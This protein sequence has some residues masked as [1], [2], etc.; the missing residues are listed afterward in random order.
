MKDLLI[1]AA[2]FLLLAVLSPLAA[3]AETVP[4]TESIVLE[5][6]IKVEGSVEKPRIIFIVPKARLWRASIIDKD[7]TEE[8]LRPIRPDKQL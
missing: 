4:A 3:E 7:F 8:L 1:I 6:V 5:R 2:A